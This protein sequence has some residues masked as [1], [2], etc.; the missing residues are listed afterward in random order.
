MMQQAK[1][2]PHPA[3]VLDDATPQFLALGREFIE[4]P[5]AVEIIRNVQYARAAADTIGIAGVPGVGK[6][7]ALRHY[8]QTWHNVWLAEMSEDAKAPVPMLEEIGAAVGMPPLPRDAARMRRM[9]VERLRG[10]GGVL[11]VDEAQHLTREAREVLRKIAD[12]AEIGMVW[13]GDKELITSMKPLPQIWS[14][15]GKWQVING[16][17]TADVTAL[18]AAFGVDGDDNLALCQELAEQTCGVRSVVKA[19]RLASFY[20]AGGTVTVKHMRAARNSLN[21]GGA[22]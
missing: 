22:A 21:L 11:L 9:I 3:T 12:S 1:E 5:T 17:A 7:R 13:A 10:T 8:A 14:R 6:S 4:T 16:P 20:A 15:I 2:T 18:C 19:L